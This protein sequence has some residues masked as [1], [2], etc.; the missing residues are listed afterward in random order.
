MVKHE[1]LGLVALLGL[2]AGAAGALLFKILHS[3]RG[4]DGPI[5]VKGGSVEVE[6][7]NTAWQTDKEDNDPEY[8]LRP[9]SRYQVRVWAHGPHNPLPCEP[10][11]AIGRRV[12]VRMEN[13]GGTFTLVLRANGSVRVI[14]KDNRLRVDAA[15]LRRLHDLD[16]STRIARVEVRDKTQTPPLVYERDFVAGQEKGFIELTLL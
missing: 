16:S 7:D 14:D 4:E 1:R 9:R 15:N 3:G 11:V 8:F 10:C 5:R 12:V 13:S 2:A 6:S